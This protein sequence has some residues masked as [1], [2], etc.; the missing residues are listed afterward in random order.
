VSTLDLVRNLKLTIA[1]DGTE[2]HG[3]QFQPGLRTVEG[4]LVDVL[5]PI[6]QTRVGLVVAGRTDAGV[7]ARGQVANFRT[8]STIDLQRFRRAA[9]SR[10]ESGIVIRR[11][12]EVAERFNARFDA[13]GK[14]YRYAL[15]ADREKPPVTETRYLRHWHQPLEV[16]A[17][18]A[19]A[20][21]LT[22]T[23][24]FK[25]FETTSSQ[26]RKSTVCHVRRLDVHRQG[27]R[28]WI[29]VE[30]DRFLYN[31][32]RN[33]VGTLLEV[34]RG[35]WPADCLPQILEARDRTAAGPTA[36]ALGL[37][38]MQ[39]FYDESIPVPSEGEA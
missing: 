37:T 8:E 31:M 1:Y 25:S 23:H 17:M 16:E 34:G 22:G 20:R 36:P 21:H 32:I 38:M 18:A 12:E 19:A 33:I 4:R 6:T 7:H 10:L 2:Y 27:E 30:G 39:V 28:V 15:W 9:N 13:R 14:H 11:I 29:D 35:R 26:P 3:W 24:D 5:S